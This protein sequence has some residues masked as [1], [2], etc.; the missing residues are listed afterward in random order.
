[1][2]ALQAA[3]TNTERCS[4]EV[5]DWPLPLSPALSRRLAPGWVHPWLLFIGY[6]NY[7]TVFMRFSTTPSK[8]SVWTSTI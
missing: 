8:A 3:A 4:Q 6:G 1:M 5:T 7:T 2:I